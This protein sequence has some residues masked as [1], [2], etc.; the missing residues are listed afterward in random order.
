[1]V[2]LYVGYEG[3][4]A[5]NSFSSSRQRQENTLYLRTEENPI[6]LESRAW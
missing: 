6:M 2:E 1:M 3:G 4:G 5:E